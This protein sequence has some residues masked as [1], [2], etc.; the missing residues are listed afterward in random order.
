MAQIFNPSERVEALALAL[1]SLYPMNCSA[2]ETAEHRTPPVLSATPA[3]SFVR[4]T[5]Y[6]YFSPGSGTESR[7]ARPR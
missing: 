2:V 4:Y 6:P 7:S 3:I 5:V 1:P